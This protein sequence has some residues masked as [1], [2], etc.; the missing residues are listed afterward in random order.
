MW[1]PTAVCAFRESG[2]HHMV[3]PGCEQHPKPTAPPHTGSQERFRNLHFG[4]PAR[5]SG[6]NVACSVAV[7]GSHVQSCGTSV[8]KSPAHQAWTHRK[9]SKACGHGGVQQQGR[10]T[11]WSSALFPVDGEQFH[12]R[13]PL[14]RFMEGLRRLRLS[15]VCG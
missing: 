1:S 13:A 9:D 7:A 3:H 11:T 10:C 14:E 8:E 4:P 15:S 5:L 2:S 6:R 12:T